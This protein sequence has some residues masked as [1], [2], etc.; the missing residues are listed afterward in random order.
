MPVLVT[1]IEKDGKT[2]ILAELQHS[3]RYLDI[4]SK[5]KIKEVP[6]NLNVTGESWIDALQEAAIRA[7][8]TGSKIR[9][10]IT[11]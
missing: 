5:I 1:I 9:K 2:V 6:T 10:V 8:N 4:M 3:K 7:Q 11:Q